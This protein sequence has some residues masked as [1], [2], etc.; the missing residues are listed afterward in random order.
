MICYI[1]R[2]NHKNVADKWLEEKLQRFFT[3]V[4]WLVTLPRF[5]VQY[6]IPSKVKFADQPS[7]LSTIILYFLLCY[8][9]FKISITMYRCPHWLKSVL[10]EDDF[11]YQAMFFSLHCANIRKK[12]VD[13]KGREWLMKDLHRPK[14]SI[15]TLSILY[16]HNLCFP[17]NRVCKLL[18][19][20]YSVALCW[21]P[22]CRAHLGVF[23]F[24]A[25]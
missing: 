21:K 15:F 24:F 14:S 19:V 22:T 3:P 23:Y 13:K 25:G 4:F 10:W 7:K 16:V 1:I 6:I 17:D 20:L 5:T 9:H 12:H 18:S 8:L 2:G 11:F